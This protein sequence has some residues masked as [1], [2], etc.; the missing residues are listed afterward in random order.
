MPR[1]NYFK[2]RGFFDFLAIFQVK[3]ST[4]YDSMTAHEIVGE[5]NLS[6][7]KKYCGDFIET[8]LTGSTIF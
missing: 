4:G 5:S 1:S 7:S 2:S 8:I 3:M 6:E